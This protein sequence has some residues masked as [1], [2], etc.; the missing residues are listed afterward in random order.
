MILL[1]VELSRENIFKGKNFDA[2][3]KVVENFHKFKTQTKEVVMNEQREEMTMSR[4][5]Q[6]IKFYRFSKLFK[7][8]NFESYF[9][10]PFSLQETSFKVFFYL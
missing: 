5:W 4:S 8:K 7:K 10:S 9:R 6:R 3:N 2:D 1:V